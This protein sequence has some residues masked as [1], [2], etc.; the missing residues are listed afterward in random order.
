[1]WVGVASASYIS[2]DTVHSKKM[3]YLM[4][5]MFLLLSALVS[6]ARVFAAGPAPE[7]ALCDKLLE[8]SYR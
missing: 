6:G 4:R 1:V 5:K 7:V 2:I 3:G 8:W